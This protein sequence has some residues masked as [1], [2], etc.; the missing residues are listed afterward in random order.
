MANYCRLPIYSKKIPKSQIPAMFSK[1]GR[2]NPKKNQKMLYNLLMSKILLIGK[3]IPE[4]Y[5]FAKGLLGSENAVFA[6]ESDSSTDSDSYSDKIYTSSWNKSSAISAHSFLIKA[7]TKLDGIDAVVFY[8]DADHLSKKF[9][10]NRSDEISTAID[11]MISPFLYI[12]D[13]I[14]RRA[15][16]KREKLVVGFV[17]KNQIE[18]ANTKIVD[19][20]LAAFSRLAEKFAENVIERDYLRVFL[21][22]SLVS[23]DSFGTEQQLG[24]WTLSAIQSLADSKKQSAKQ[25]ASWNKAGAKLG[26]GFPF[27]K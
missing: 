15:E 22:K 25:A 13:E 14:L 9:I 18:A 16:Q 6:A 19:V 10:D 7:E 1:K 24:D 20:S 21:A 26:S 27:F 5:D 2:K 3:D 12:T 17:I 23:S 4:A 8:F 11:T